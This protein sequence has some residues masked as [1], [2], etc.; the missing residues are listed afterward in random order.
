MDPWRTVDDLPPGNLDLRRYIA[1]RYLETGAPVEVDEIVITTGAAEA[2]LLSLQAVTRPGDVTA[3]ES[4]AF[5]LPLSA[6]EALGL[7]VVPIAVTRAPASTWTRSRQ[8]SRDTASRRC[9]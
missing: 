6:A 7:R 2:L 8:R 9:G 3:V 4:P 5:Y 1:R